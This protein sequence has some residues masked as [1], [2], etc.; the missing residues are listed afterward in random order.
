MSRPRATM[1]G[2]VVVILLLVA[3]PFTASAVEGDVNLVFIHHSVGTNWLGDGLTTSLNA[4]G[5][6]VADITYGWTGGSGT[7]YGDYTDTDDWPT[8]FDNTVM[9]LV[10]PETDATAAVNTIDPAPGENTVI[11]FKSCYPNS[12]VGVG[13]DDEKAIY[14]SLIPY[15][16][17]HP[18]KMF[19]LCTPPP[20]ATISTPQETREL[21]GWLTDRGG[22]WLKDLTTGNVFVF[23]MYNVLTHP[24]AHH[25]M[26]GGVETYAFEPGFN[27]LHP[28]YHSA[29][30]DHPNTLANTKLTGEF[31]P[32][33]DH[34]YAEFAVTSGIAAARYQQD[35][36]LFT[37]LG[38]WGTEW[39]W[40]YSGGS[41]VRT[42]ATDSAVLVE[43]TG[44]YIQVLAKTTPWYGIAEVSLDGGPWEPVDYYTPTT[45]YKN[46]VYTAGGLAD[47]AHTLVIKCTGTK[48][49]SSWGYRIGVDAFDILGTPT[50]ADEPD[51]YEED[52]GDFNY[53][54][55]WTSSA[56]ASASG[57]SRVSIDESNGAV[58]VTFTGMSLAWTARTTPWYGRAMVVLDGG[59]PVFVDLYS[60]SVRNRR[61]VYSTGLLDMGP[62]TVSVYWTGTRNWR[63]WGKQICVD[64]FEI[65]GDPTAAPAADPIPLRY[66]DRDSKLTYLGYWRT[67]WGTTNSGGSRRSTSQT[68]AAVLIEFTGTSIDVVGRTAPW[69][70]IAEVTLDGVVQ[71]PVDFYSGSI[72]Y[73]QTLYS[74]SGL[75]DEA[76]TLVFRCTGTKNASSGG[77]SINLDAMDIR[78][79]LDQAATRTRY[80]EDHADFNYTGTWNVS[81]TWQSSGGTYVSSNDSGA[82][83]NV[84]F[85]GTSIAWYATTAPWYGRAWVK[86]DGGA[87]Q[88]VD[89]WSTTKKYKQKVYDTGLL[90]L[91]SHTL[92]IYW[93]NDKY[94]K[95]WGTY[96][97]VDNFDI[98]GD[99]TSAPAADP[100]PLR[101]E[102]D[103]SRITYCGDRWSKKWK[104]EASRANYHYT[105][106][107]GA[108]AV[109][110]FTG[111]DIDIVART[112]PWYGKARITLDGAEEEADLYSSEVLYR[113]TVYSKTGLADTSH[114]LT[115]ECSGYKNVDSSGY[116]ITVD[117]LDIVGSLDQAPVAQRYQEWNDI[118]EYTLDWDTKYTWAA[119]GGM[120][121]YTNKNDR[122]L[123]VEFSGIYLAYYAKTA[124]W[125]GHATVTLD[126]GTPGEVVTTVNFHSS[127]QQYR[128][129]VY[130]TGLIDDGPHT[131]VIERSDPASSLLGIS[132]DAFDIVTPSP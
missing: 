78:G 48:N 62:H 112:A 19:V 85:T 33:L 22:G 58:N 30:D 43:F 29:G 27:T 21:C 109:V 59:A 73:L 28:D 131:L 5:Y 15:F 40:S 100:I 66:Q 128:Q 113:Q 118:C 24:D 13:I 75:D 35:N 44:E 55:T 54:G 1:L 115:I 23:D 126:P 94:W 127:T 39:S 81:T 65:L 110:E 17:A 102:Q 61:Q 80:Q 11:M 97:S 2:I 90:D 4:S 45:V 67:N 114:T 56:D 107:V 99:P 79:T 14:N 7:P 32:L 125:Y 42:D 36:P 72:G 103:S 16:E 3:M 116:A 31:V 70:G 25:R 89:L 123:T 104:S 106:W 53:T 119:S 18:D 41:R 101:Y 38:D 84:T 10:Y 9:N 98:M 86:L 50:Q 37:Y 74:E 51:V 91:D 52:H 87:P 71:D 64:T 132:V 26:S 8:W 105:S 47:E 49:A 76:H 108:V 124:P 83:V 95:S 120:H 77:Y 111:T 117:A 69:Y 92:T 121:A 63:S 68:D 93:L 60:S 96:I 20:M 57:G 122:P 88:K 129:L 46:P 130:D 34:W 6:H 82:A 12:D